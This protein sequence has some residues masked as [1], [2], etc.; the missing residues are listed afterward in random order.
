MVNKNKKQAGKPTSKSGVS[1]TLIV[2]LLFA[3]GANQLTLA[4]RI[5]PLPN[6]PRITPPG[7]QMMDDQGKF[8]GTLSLRDIAADPPTSR[9]LTQIS[10]KFDGRHCLL[11]TSR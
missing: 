2:L 1:L 6:G 9:T 4:Q 5:R 11:K 7:N 8:K 3:V 10:W